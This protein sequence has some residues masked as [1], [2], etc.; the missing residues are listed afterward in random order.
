MFYNSKR[1]WH[2]ECLT[3]LKEEEEGEGGESEQT[4]HNLQSSKLKKPHYE[5][6]MQIFVG[7]TCCIG[8]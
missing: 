6:N 1:G 3:I 5:Q 7:N 8:C 2:V 4:S